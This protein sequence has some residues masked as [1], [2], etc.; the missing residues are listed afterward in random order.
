LILLAA[1]G[2]LAQSPGTQKNEA[3]PTMNIQEC[4]AK[5]V[6]QT[7]SASITLDLNWRWL[8]NVGGYTNCYTGNTWDATL[9][10][11]E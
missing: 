6:C 5:N 2:I 11:N 3:H 10:P 7:K 9:C 8:H 1:N 4:T